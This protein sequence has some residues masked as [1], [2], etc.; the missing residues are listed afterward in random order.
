LVSDPFRA[1][2]EPAASTDRPHVREAGVETSGN[3]TAI[4][5]NTGLGAR[6]S[7]YPVEAHLRFVRR[8]DSGDA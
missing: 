6:S 5:G 4:E 8:A 7:H 3:Y 2:V 1:S